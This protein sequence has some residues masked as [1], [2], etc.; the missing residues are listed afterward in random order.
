MIKFKAVTAN[1]E[2]V[3]SA[4]SDFV[5]P[6]GE[7][8]TKREDRRILEPV[9][10]AVIAHSAATMHDDLFQLAMWNDYIKNAEKVENA[11]SGIRSYYP[12]R[13]LIMPYVPGA[14]ADRGT[15]F[16][17][18]VYADFLDALDLDHIAVFDPHSPV[19]E[20]LLA[21]AAPLTVLRP[22][23]VLP[24]HLPKD[25][26]DAVI[27]PDKGAYR[28]A[29]E[30]ADALGLPLIQGE[31]RRDFESGKFLGYA[32]PKLSQ[33]EQYLVVDDICDAGG[34]FVLLGEAA[35]VPYGNLHLYVSHGIFSK[36]GFERLT[37]SHYSR[38]IT[39]NSYLGGHPGNKERDG[40]HYLFDVVRPL[41]EALPEELRRPVSAHPKPTIN[42]YVSGL[43]ADRIAEHVISSYLGGIL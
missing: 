36:G 21:A 40:H 28:R 29:V 20:Q 22:V 23:D 25:A 14:R 8:H 19:S 27:A 35:S 42:T 5:F 41:F 24:K 11:Y 7:R 13:V 33:T 26:Y 31:K 4:I 38:I 9:E 15:P 10:V 18:K 6:A 16:G 34:T 43:S 37:E 3:N 2:F 1:G 32:L 39:T 12:K 17:A 30:V